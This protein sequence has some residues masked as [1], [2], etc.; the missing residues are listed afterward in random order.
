VYHPGKVIEVFRKADKDVVSAD[1]SAQ[2][3]V[4]MWDENVLTL[5]VS[6]KI[7]DKIKSGQ[8]VLADYRADEKHEPPVPRHE[9]VKIISGKRAE[10]AWEAYK[11]MLESRKRKAKPAAEKLPAQSYIG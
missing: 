5:L 3:V 9:I 8:M 10:R 2:A 6:P 1:E 7:S 11:D 4:E